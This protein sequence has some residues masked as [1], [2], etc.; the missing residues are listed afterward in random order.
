MHYLTHHLS[1]EEEDR[2]YAE[3]LLNQICYEYYESFEEEYFLYSQ[4]FDD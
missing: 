1:V 4:Y 3:E 2:F